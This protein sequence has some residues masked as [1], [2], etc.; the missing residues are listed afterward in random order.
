MPVADTSELAR[1]GVVGAA[2]TA[3]YAAM[4]FLLTHWLWLG[5]TPG[6]A[7]LV[8]Y[9]V[10]AAFSYLAHKS[11]TFLS[12]GPHR[13]EGLRFLALSAIGIVVAFAAPS[14]LTGA[15]GFDPIFAILSTCVLVPVINFVV[16][17]RWVFAGRRTDR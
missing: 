4:A 3:L 11:V 8:A 15:L 16:M 7:S 17:D 12:T 5:L 10:A 13:L 2:A 6:E 1:F 14:I 9:I